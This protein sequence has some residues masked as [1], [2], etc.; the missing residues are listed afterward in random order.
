M[1]WDAVAKRT[2]VTGGHTRVLGHF[3]VCS[4]WVLTASLHSRGSR[5]CSS[6]VPASSLTG[7]PTTAFSN[8]N[9]CRC[10][11]MGCSICKVAGRLQGSMLFCTSAAL[12]TGSSAAAFQKGAAPRC[13]C[14]REYRSHGAPLWVLS[15]PRHV[16]CPLPGRS[17][18]SRCGAGPGRH[19][20]A[21]RS[22]PAPPHAAFCLLRRGTAEPRPNWGSDA[23]AA[24]ACHA[25]MASP[26]VLQI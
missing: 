12:C 26:S 22:P 16:S 25:V 15:P 10:L 3:K 9:R 13:R 7:R 4:S 1:R 18:R 2:A 19:I 17:R 6:P 8:Q 23:H 5:R 21:G 20:A 11:V 24:Q 14:S